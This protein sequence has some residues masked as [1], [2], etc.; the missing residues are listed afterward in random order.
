MMT[1]GCISRGKSDEV[2]LAMAL[3][4]SSKVRERREL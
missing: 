4:A 2:E 1:A 3:D